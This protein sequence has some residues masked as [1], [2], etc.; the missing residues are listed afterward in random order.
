VIKGRNYYLWSIKERN[1]TGRPANKYWQTIGWRQ[2]CDPN[3]S[4]DQRNLVFTFLLPGFREEISY[5][6]RNHQPIVTVQGTKV[7][8]QGNDCQN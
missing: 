4:V 2:R 3:I 5:K 6:W 8:H 7:M 1:R